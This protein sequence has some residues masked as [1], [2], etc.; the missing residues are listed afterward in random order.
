MVSVLGLNLLR[1]STPQFFFKFG[2]LLLFFLAS[3]DELLLVVF[4]KVCTKRSF[5]SV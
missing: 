1:F 5:A 3:L 2:G 4:L